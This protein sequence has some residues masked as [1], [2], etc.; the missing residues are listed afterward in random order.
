MARVQEDM[1]S[2]PSVGQESSALLKWLESDWRT[3]DRVGKCVEPC[4]K[5]PHALFTKGGAA[6][7]SKGGD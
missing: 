5:D 3:T 1:V 6:H 7:T 4:G 2:T